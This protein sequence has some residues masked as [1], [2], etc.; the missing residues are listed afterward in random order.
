MKRRIAVLAALAAASTTLLPAVTSAPASAAGQLPAVRVMPLGDSISYGEGSSTLG[1]YRQPLRE[2]VAGQ[3][4]YTVDFVG[5]LA[6]GPTADAEHEGHAGYTVGQ[7]RSG[8]ERWIP[9]AAPD[10]VLLHI[11]L[12][13]LNQGA[14]PDR[15]ADQTRD[16]V[17]RI[18]ALRPGATVIVQGLVPSTPGWNY[19]DLSQPIARYN[20]RLKELEA[21][22]QQ[23]GRH[24]RF[25]DAPALTP[26]NRADAGH[27]AQMADGLHPNDRGYTELARAFF[28]PLDQARTAGWFTGGP[29][30][31]GPPRPKN[32]VHLQRVAPDGALANAEGD[33]AA[34]SWSGWGDFGVTGMKE[35]TSAPTGS[36]NRVFA[37]GGDDRV[38]E[39]DGDYAAGAW[40]GWFQ[41]KDA[42]QAKAIS[43]SSDGNT[44]HLVVVGADGQLYNADGDYSAGKWNGWTGHG[45]TGLKRVTSATTA[46][47]V[48]HIF[49]T[50]ANDRIVELDA[51][52]AAGK[53]GNW[54]TA[55]PTG[56]F[57]ALDIAASVAGKVVH[58]GAI[59]QDG[60]WYNTDGDFA[61]GSWNGWWNG[62]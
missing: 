2:L 37:I 49:A 19:Q 36:V 39:N 25:V 29:V 46:D 21:A 42:P 31:P 34:G 40:S 38:Y 54:G 55:G 18:F 4:R 28:T 20:Q 45:G 1:G 5:S 43:A 48:N 24:F 22:Q 30:R 11:G 23:S 27:P 50:D 56:G 41:L 14:D 12:N 35:I 9:A 57:N 17:D 7:V 59:G 16:L 13:D 32:T 47:H 62:G 60:N 61:G 52:Y 6:H 26:A 3:S 58:L 8:V 51:D 33:Y 53:W 15:T 44:V 10:V